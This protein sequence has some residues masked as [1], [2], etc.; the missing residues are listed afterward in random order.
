MIVEF[1]SAYTQ[2]L[3]PSPFFLLYHLNGPLLPS[4]S[5]PPQALKE[6]LEQR[7]LPMEERIEPF[8]LVF[9]AA[10]EVRR[11]VGRGVEGVQG[12]G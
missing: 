6:S 7:G 2:A 5:P 12:G 11:Q 10:L 3:N 9:K 8:R 4:P 1:L